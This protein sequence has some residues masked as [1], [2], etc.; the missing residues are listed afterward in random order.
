[1]KA[2]QYFDLGQASTLEVAR[3][4]QV[5]RF[6]PVIE[7]AGIL[8]VLKQSESRQVVQSGKIEKIRL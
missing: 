4:V 8:G 7:T 5:P 2:T 6:L 3:P 1:M